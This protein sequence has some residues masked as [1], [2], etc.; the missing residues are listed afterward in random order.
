MSDTLAESLRA[1][2]RCDAPA[3]AYLA[4]VARERVPRLAGTPEDSDEDLVLRLRDPRVFGEFAASLLEDAGLPSPLREAVAERVFDLLPLPRGEGDVIVVE[5]RAPKGLLAIADFV[6]AARGLTVLHVMHLVFAV[7]LDR[8]IVR[9]A[10]KKV[11][12][13]ILARVLA[14]A[15]ANPSLRVL[16]AAMH[17]AA[18]PEAEAHRAFRGILRMRGLEDGVKFSLARAAA[19]ED[20]GVAYLLTLARDEGLVST[21][22]TDPSAPEVVANIPRLPPRLAAIGRRSFAP[23]R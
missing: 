4:T 5:G 19:S 14:Q 1:D 11:R 20:G 23:V 2:L 17:L 6:A 9:E 18:V 21:E 7:F 3:A 10:E 13:M 22:W 15:E 12:S 8:G 16:Y